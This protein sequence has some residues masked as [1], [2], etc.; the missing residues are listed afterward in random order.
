MHF[1]AINSVF[2]LELDNTDY[3][4]RAGEPIKAKVWDMGRCFTCSHCD[5]G[6][7][8]TDPKGTKMAD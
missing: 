1:D 5:I 7:P 3:D 8:V 4:I 2:A 6:E